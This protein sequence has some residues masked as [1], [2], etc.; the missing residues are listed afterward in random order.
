[1]IISSQGGREYELELAD[2]AS[3][4]QGCNESVND[5]IQIF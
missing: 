5:Y 3:L 2:L 1:M 4:R